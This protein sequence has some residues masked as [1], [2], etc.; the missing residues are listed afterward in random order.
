MSVLDGAGVTDTTADGGWE[1]VTVT[2]VLADPAV[3]LDAHPAHLDGPAAWAAYLAHLDEAG[4]CSLPAPSRSGPVTDFP[5][6]LAAWTAPA[7]AGADPAALNGDGLAWGWACSR[8]LLAAPSHATVNVRKRP[9]TDAA[10]RYAKDGKWDIGAGPLKARDVPFAAVI[11]RE[12]RWHALADP[13]ALLALLRR[14]HHLGRLGGHGNGRVLEWRVEPH[15]DRGAWRDRVMPLEGGA[16]GSVR[17]PYWHPSRRMP[18][19]P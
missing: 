14:V 13:P 16:P 4:H 3:S 2:A 18:C 5:L 12:A 15:A 9:E 8:V 7:P 1:P 11:A 6:P 17:A 19:T 10:A